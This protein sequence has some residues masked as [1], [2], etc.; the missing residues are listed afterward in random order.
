L[1]LP[2]HPFLFTFFLLQ[3]HLFFPFFPI[4]F[5]LSCSLFFSFIHYFF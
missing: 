4:L 2:F 5:S 3:L 1:L